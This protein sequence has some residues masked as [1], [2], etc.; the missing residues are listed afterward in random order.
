[1]L[2]LYYVCLVAHIGVQHILTIWIAWRWS[3]ERHA[4]LT[5]HEHLS[6][7]PVFGGVPVGHLFSFLCCVF[8]LFAFVLCRVYSIMPVSL[9]CPFLISRSVFLNVYLIETTCITRSENNPSINVLSTWYSVC[10]YVPQVYI[11]DILLF[12]FN[13]QSINQS[14]GSNCI[15]LHAECISY[16]YF[17]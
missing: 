10:K 4:L 14:M 9:D 7:H 13:Q 15:P 16:L 1:M 8:V 5:V 12:E 2:Y 17:I 11:A 3:C 6:S